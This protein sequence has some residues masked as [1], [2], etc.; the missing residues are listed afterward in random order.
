MA[1]EGKKPGSMLDLHLIL[2]SLDF[3][4]LLVESDS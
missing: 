4:L 2:E 1:T 3:T